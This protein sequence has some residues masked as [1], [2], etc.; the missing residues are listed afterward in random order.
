MPNGGHMIN[1]SAKNLRE[2]HGRAWNIKWIILTSH[3]IR[4]IFVASHGVRIR[5]TQNELG[6][7]AAWGR[8]L[9]NRTQAP[10]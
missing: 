7:N 5:R 2:C 1:I 4:Y 3:R 8:I 10:K 9:H 6:A